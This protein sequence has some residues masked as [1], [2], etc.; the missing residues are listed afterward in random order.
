[1]LY[2]ST[3][4]QAIN[5]CRNQPHICTFTAADQDGAP[6]SLENVTSAYLIINMS[7][8]NDQPWPY[9]GYLPSVVQRW[10]TG[11]SLGNP[12]IEFELTEMMIGGLPLGTFVTEFGVSEDD[13]QY[14][15][16]QQG[17]ITIS[18]SLWSPA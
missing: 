14:V 5:V 4:Q 10:N 6:V 2:L 7:L 11:F 3:L 13:V 17:T 8:Y 16:C 18:P 15:V 9:P 12:A 1:M